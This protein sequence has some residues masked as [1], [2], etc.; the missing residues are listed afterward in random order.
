VDVKTVARRVLVDGR[1]QGVGFRQACAEAARRRGLG[2]WVRN[3]RDGRVEAFFEGS[4]A[5]VAHLVDWCRQGPVMASVSEVHVI[6]EAPTGTAGF[7]IAVT[8]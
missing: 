4:V 2:G 7:R 6:D 3:R 8:G 1:V 5:D